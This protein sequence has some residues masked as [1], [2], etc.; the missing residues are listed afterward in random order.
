MGYFPHGSGGSD[1]DMHMSHVTC[2]MA[3]E[4]RSCLR[5]VV[6]IFTQPGY[7]ML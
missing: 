1:I 7:D 2:H 4:T 3:A 6:V 5:V